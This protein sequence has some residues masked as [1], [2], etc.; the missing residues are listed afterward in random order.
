MGS[1][2]ELRII[3]KVSALE[4]KTQT[5]G[6]GRAIETEQESRNRLS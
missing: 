4:T 5:H 1:P 2:S 6:S 3:C